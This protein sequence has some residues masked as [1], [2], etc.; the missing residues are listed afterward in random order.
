MTQTSGNIQDELVRRHRS[1]AMVVA[2]LLALTLVLL[3]IAFV[4][5][6][7]IYRPG[8]PTLAMALWITILIF[9]LGAFALRRTKFATMRLQD[10]AA[11]R[12]ISG[13]LATLQGTTVQ[14][15]FLGGAIALMGFI[16]TIQTGNPYDML[17]AA[18]VA[19][20]VLLYCYPRRAAW[21][22]VVWGIEQ[23]GEANYPPAKG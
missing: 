2:G 13:L 12:G 16:V 20:I 6:D 17:R 4:W 21:Q 8:N 7:F 22:R 10:V 19:T 5:I 11:L 23:T 3:L 14:V 9:G 1:A 18:G 15:A